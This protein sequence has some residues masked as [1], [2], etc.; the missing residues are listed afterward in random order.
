MELLHN[1]H[2][3]YWSYHYEPIVQ[4]EYTI[5]K[6]QYY[7]DCFIFFQGKSKAVPVLFYFLSTASGQAGD[8]W[9][10]IVKQVSSFFINFDY[11]NLNGELLLAHCWTL[12]L[13]SYRCFPA[14]GTATS[15][16]PG[17]SQSPA[18]ALH[19]WGS[20]QTTSNPTPWHPGW[21]SAAVGATMMKFNS[22][23]K[24]VQFSFVKGALMVGARH[25]PQLCARE[26]LVV[27]PAVVNHESN[28][29]D[30]LLES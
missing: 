14:D 10:G 24:R 8:S 12:K 28:W 16:N 21:S 11:L 7:D 30:S 17:E 27:D 9:T 18:T 3:H 19:R 5:V 6:Q 22:W 1:E 29:A 20:W 13:R 15:S 4:H 25:G 2:I 26:P 23:L